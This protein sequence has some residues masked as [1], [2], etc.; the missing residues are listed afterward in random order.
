MSSP[1]ESILPPTPSI[2]DYEILAVLGRGG[3]GIVYLAR[4]PALKRL[5]CVKVLSDFGDEAP[6]VC[7]A[8]FDREAELLASVV[9]PH[10]LSIF[11]FGVAGDP[12]LPY[13]VTEYIEGGDLRRRLSGTNPL[14]LAEARSL[15]LQVGEALEFLH[16][17]GIIHRDLKPENIFMP[18]SS[19]CKVGDFGLAVRQ[20]TAGHLTRS[21]RG[22]GTAGY[23]SPEQQY[24]LKV[25]ERSDQYSLAALAY[26]LLTSKRPLGRFTAPSQINQSL[27]AEVDPVILRGLADEPRDRYPSVRDFL[28][29]LEAALD[30]PARGRPSRRR[31]PAVLLAILVMA[32]AAILIA[33]NWTTADSGILPGDRAVEARKANA[34]VPA[35][36]NSST[37]ASDL[38]PPQRSA[39]F[40]ALVKH[41]SYRLWVE[42]GSPAGKLGD[43]IREKNWQEAERQVDAEVNLRA[44]QYWEKQGCPQGAEGEAVSVKNRRR[45][46]A[47]LLKECEEAL[48]KSP[49]RTDPSP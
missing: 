48:R 5:V 36:E 6:Q 37:G 2:P 18:T 30:H 10:V 22:L 15:L 38:L 35:A 24:G 8:R 12:A 41:R 4:Q 7:R 28:N 27:P 25:D 1:V 29:D 16:G 42:Q 33:R 9:H 21:D 19:L 26:E 47:D 11:D 45:A 46:E 40:V 34:P 32:F 3:M 31:T 14:P 39:D 43:S 44:Y 49:G 17:K 23:V 13:L 20:D